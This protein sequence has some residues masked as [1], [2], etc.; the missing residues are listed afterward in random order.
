MSGHGAGRIDPA[1][2]KVALLIAYA[3]GA[4]AIT[5]SLIGLSWPTA[6]H[7]L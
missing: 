2:E 4:I 7:P 6:V 3:L 5:F 1:N